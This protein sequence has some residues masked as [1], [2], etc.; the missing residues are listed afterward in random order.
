MYWPHFFCA[1]ALG[2]AV[3]AT[4][5]SLLGYYFGENWH[6]LEKWIG[7]SGLIALVCF[8]LIGVPLIWH[9]FRWA[10]PIKKA[11]APPAAPPATPE[12]GG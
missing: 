12:S 11:P 8:L 6:L 7:R 4:T 9:Q 2:A 10:R 3:W 5:I 1:N